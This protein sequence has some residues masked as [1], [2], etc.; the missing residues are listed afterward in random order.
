MVVRQNFTFK[1]LLEGTL[2]ELKITNVKS[3]SLLV[4]DIDHNGKFYGYEGKYGYG[5]KKGNKKGKAVD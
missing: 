4:N 2:N 1:N 5:Y 3:L